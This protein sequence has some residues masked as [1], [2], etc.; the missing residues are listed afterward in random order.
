MATPLIAHYIF[1]S[2]FWA[3]N[4]PVGTPDPSWRA[5]NNDKN[6][7]FNFQIDY[8]APKDIAA[9]QNNT[10]TENKIAKV[11]MD[12]WNEQETKGLGEEVR[13]QR[14][15]FF[16]GGRRVAGLWRGN[17]NDEQTKLNLLWTSINQAEQRY[18]IEK[19]EE[20]TSLI[21]PEPLNHGGTLSAFY[22]YLFI[23]LEDKFSHWRIVRQVSRILTWVKLD[24]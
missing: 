18:D 12:G 10:G 4:T 7:I 24:M 17:I 5:N 20:L 1:L 16:V 6:D 19:R 23:F 8:K 13:F 15:Q 2:P 22:F 14:F 9:E 3:D 11:A 21:H